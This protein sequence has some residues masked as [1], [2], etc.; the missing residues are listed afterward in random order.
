VALEPATR[1]RGDE[2][3]W[4]EFGLEWVAAPPVSFDPLASPLLFYPPLH[5]YLLGA[6]ATLGGGLGAVK[7]VQALLGALLVPAVALVGRRT[8]GPGVGLAAAAAAAFYP[9]LVWYSAHF[10]S[11]PLFLALLWWGLERAL[12]ADEGRPGAAAASGALLGLAA[13]TREVPLY[14][15]PLLA[16]WMLGRRDRASLVRAVVL[17]AAATAVVAPWTLRNRV[18]FGAFVPVSTMGGRALWEG[19]RLG[20]RGELYAEHDRIARE[21]GPVAAYRHAT[22]EGLRS[23]RERQPRWILDKTVDELGQLFTPIDMALVHLQKG[24]YGPPSLRAAWVVVAVTVPPYVAAMALFVV[25][26]ARVRWTR[27][28]AL[29]LLFFA[30]YL[31]AHVVVLGHHRFRLPL[32]PVVFTVGASVLPGLSGAAAPWTAAR[33]LLAAALLLAFAVPVARDLFGLPGDPAFRD[34]P[35]RPDDAEQVGLQSIS[36]ANTYQLPS[37]GV[38][39]SKAARSGLL[40]WPG[41]RDGAH[42]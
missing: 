16:A 9:T 22:R 30:F 11:E 33:R 29:L 18:R 25:G 1:P 6:A 5:P 10:W 26:L 35:A 23:I 19:N 39:S 20:D 13:L 36:W 21:E 12:A 3:T 17:V 15:L 34:V 27:G 24:G 14:F 28:R 8:F 4:I 31:L 37:I 7:V 41:G 2:R 38:Y 32:L 40:G 42:V